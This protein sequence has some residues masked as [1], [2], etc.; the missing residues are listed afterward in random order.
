MGNLARFLTEVSDRPFQ[1][2]RHDCLTFADR[3]VTLQ[4]GRGFVTEWLGHYSSGRAALL[5][6]RRFAAGSRRYADLIEVADDRLYRK[7]TLHPDFG[8]VVARPTEGKGIG[9]AFG[10]ATPRGVAFVGDFGLEFKALEP[11]DKVWGVMP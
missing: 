10:V 4:R 11:F 5:R 6:Y 3:A 8:D 9:L 7:M 1:W 2:G